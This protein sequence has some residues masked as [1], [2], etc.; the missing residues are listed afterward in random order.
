MKIGLDRNLAVPM[1][2]GKIGAELEARLAEH[3]ALLRR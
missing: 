2:R 3:A 1:Y